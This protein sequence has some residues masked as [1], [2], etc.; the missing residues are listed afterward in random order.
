[1]INLINFFASYNRKAKEIHEKIKQ[2][3]DLC[4]VERQLTNSSIIQVQRLR[5]N[6]G[7]LWFFYQDFSMDDIGL[8][9]KYDLDDNI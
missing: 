1:M 2:S 7:Y 9:F 6:D 4:N 5:M 3:I 8:S